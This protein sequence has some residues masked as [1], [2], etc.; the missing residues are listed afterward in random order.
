VHHL[1]CGDFEQ[2]CSF[3]PLPRRLMERKYFMM[4]DDGISIVARCL[5][6]S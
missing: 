4:N 3:H 2:D 6:P 5:T 1:S